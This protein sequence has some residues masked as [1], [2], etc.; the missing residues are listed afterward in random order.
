MTKFKITTVKAGNFG[1][2]D[3]L[4][5]TVFKEYLPPKDKYLKKKVKTTYNR[6]LH[7]EQDL[8]RDFLICWSHDLKKNYLKGV[9]ISDKLGFYVILELI[10]RDDWDLP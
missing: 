10:I 9:Q 6:V 8:I 3:P 4:L 7:A 2:S 1:Q 5:E